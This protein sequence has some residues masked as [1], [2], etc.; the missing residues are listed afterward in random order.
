MAH[1]RWRGIPIKIELYHA[2]KFGN[3]AKVAEELNRVL[4]SRGNQVSVHHISEARPKELPTADLYIFGS[5]TRFG[6]PIGK[7]RRFAKK[8]RLPPGTR[9]AVFATH[10]DEVPDKKTGIMPTQEELDSKR[11]TTPELDEILK[12]K[13]LVKVADKVFVV[14][15]DS[16]KGSLRETM[17]GSLK[18]GWQAKAEEFAD[19]IL[20]SGQN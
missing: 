7:M 20:G 1:N 17:A 16:K 8:V 6:R 14:I 5:P 2:S 9:Y 15:V 3:G 11:R 19:A 12:G 4:E 10:S 18:E 13:G